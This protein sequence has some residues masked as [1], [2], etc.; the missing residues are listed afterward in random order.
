[1]LWGTQN[2]GTF[3]VFGLALA[4]ALFPALMQAGTAGD[5]GCTIEHA[6]GE[7]E[8][9]AF[10]VSVDGVNMIEFDPE[11]EVYEVMLAGEPEVILIHALSKDPEATVSYNLSD[12][13]APV[14]WGTLETGGQLF[15]LESVPEGHSLLNVWVHAS[16]GKADNY[17]V[18][19]AR[20]EACQ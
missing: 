20:P 12:G 5:G 11:L 10:S 9:E 17:T 6:A 3:R 8:L 18:F 13:C 19:F 15:M 14:E 2:R 7:T 1:M 4:I 16:E